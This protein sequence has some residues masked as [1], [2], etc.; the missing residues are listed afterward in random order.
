MATSGSQSF[1]NDQLLIPTALKITT[2]YS[3]HYPTAWHLIHI[4]KF[5]NSQSGLIFLIQ[6]TRVQESDYSSTHR[7]N[8]YVGSFATRSSTSSPTSILPSITT[9]NNVHNLFTLLQFPTILETPA[10][11]RHP[12][13]KDPRDRHRP[14]KARQG[15]EAP[16]Q[17]EPRESCHP[18]QR[19]EIPQPCSSCRSCA[20][21]LKIMVLMLPRFSVRHFCKVQTRMI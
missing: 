1:P 17:T 14:R 21:V 7:V 16:A 13:S 15:I 19:A 11:L 20:S 3:V 2:N 9:I 5:A 12:T 10:S 8:P 18:I 4:N 6:Q